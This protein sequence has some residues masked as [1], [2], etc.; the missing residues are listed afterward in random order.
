MY[1]VKI[2]YSAFSRSSLVQS[3]EMIAPAVL[4]DHSEYTLDSDGA[5]KFIATAA[6]SRN[7]AMLSCHHANW[8]LFCGKNGAV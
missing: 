2:N 1:F 5:I 6:K 3:S 8:S 4:D 7:V